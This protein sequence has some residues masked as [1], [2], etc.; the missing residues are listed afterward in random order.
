M[1]PAD[2]GNSEF[3]LLNKFLLHTR[4][5]ILLPAIRLPSLSRTIL[6]FTPRSF[7]SPLIH[8]SFLPSLP[9]P[10]IPFY[11]TYISLHSHILHRYQ[12][13]NQL[14]M[15]LGASTINPTILSAL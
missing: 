12:N 7:I 3:I 11:A 1:K 6:S 2:Y 9:L 13:S 5:I 14:F 10:V 8:S 15:R 4:L